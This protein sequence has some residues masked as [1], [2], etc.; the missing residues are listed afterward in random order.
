MI[1]GIPAKNEEIIPCTLT[2]DQDSINLQS[3]GND[4]AVVVR[5][6]DDGDIEGMTGTSLA[7]D[8]I[9]VRREALPG[10]KW[11]ALFAVSSTS[12]KAGN[13]KVRFETPCGKK[14]VAVKV[15]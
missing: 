2:L 4:R 3:G 11:T 8:D 5:R 7:P 6:T 10:V 9:S 14:E 1:S 15:Q 13:Y 12:G